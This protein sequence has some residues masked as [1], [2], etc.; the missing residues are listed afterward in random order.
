M[1]LGK[2]ESSSSPGSIYGSQ[3]PYLQE[4]YAGASNAY[5]APQGIDP[6]AQQVAN[7]AMGGYQTQMGGGIVDPTLQQNLY[8]LASGQVQNQALGGA[9]QAGL[10]DINQN[11]TRNMLPA[12]GTGAAMTNT[13]GGSRQGIAEGLALSDANQQATD[14]VN[15]MYS[16]NFGQTLESMLGAN[17]QLGGLNSQ[18]NLAQQSA[19]GYS[20]EMAL[21]GISPTQMAL[22]QQYAPLQAYGNILGPPVPL[23]GGSSSSGWNVGISSKE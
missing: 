1:S 11:L 19:L 21:L 6:Y 17:Q 10:T 5:N 16:Q 15:Q 14:F 4:L 23:S 13:S 9:I 7:S 12:I 18:Q 8:G 22:Q 3:D 2:S 20:P